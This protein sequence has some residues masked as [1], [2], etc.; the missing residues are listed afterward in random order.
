ML[1]F[2]LYEKVT[3]ET[4]LRSFCFCK[5]NQKADARTRQKLPVA[6]FDVSET[7]ET[8]SIVSGREQDDHVSRSRLRPATSVQ[9]PCGAVLGKN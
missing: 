3:K 5:K 1:L 6:S 2:R 7:A 4:F 8:G 9:N